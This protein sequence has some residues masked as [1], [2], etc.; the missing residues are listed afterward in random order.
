MSR[1]RRNKRSGKR[2]R[3]EIGF[4]YAENNRRRR[5][6]LPPMPRGKLR[7][8]G[9]KVGDS[10][11]RR[12]EVLLALG[13]RT[14]GDYLRSR[15]WKSIRKMVYNALGNSCQTCG[16]KASCIHHLDYSRDTLMGY[17]FDSL[18]PLCRACHERVEF[19]Q[20]GSKRTVREAAAE[21]RSLMRLYSSSGSGGRSGQK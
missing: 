2:S 12:T 4:W 21:C 13:Y 8:D 5:A 9:S 11:T 20:D 19:K 15:L 14:Y 6:G 18:V 16:Q 17:R 1:R 7:F 10:Y 3:P